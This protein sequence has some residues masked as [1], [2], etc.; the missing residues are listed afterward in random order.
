M[1]IIYGGVLLHLLLSSFFLINE[2]PRLKR[3][4]RGTRWFKQEISELQVQAKEGEKSRI[5]SQVDG[6]AS[7][8]G[9]SRERSYPTWYCPISFPSEGLKIPYELSSISVYKGI[10]SKSAAT[11]S[12]TGPVGK[13]RYVGPIESSYAD[14]VKG[15]HTLSFSV[16]R[17]SS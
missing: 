9:S 14:S 16:K 11:P 15:I 2:E 6:Y 17:R 12:Q 7:K 13:N 3:S 1:H 8:E 5:H 10:R 4:Q